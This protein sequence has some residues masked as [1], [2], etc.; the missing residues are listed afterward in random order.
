MV[1]LAAQGFCG[2]VADGMVDGG[3]RQHKN[4]CQAVK[5]HRHL[6]FRSRRSGMDEQ[7]DGGRDRDQDADS[8]SGGIGDFLAAGIMVRMGFIVQNVRLSSDCFFCSGG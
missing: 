6:C 8:V 5:P 1:E 3:S 2:R 7:Q 4:Q